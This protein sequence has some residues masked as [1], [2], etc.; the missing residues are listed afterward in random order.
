M[1]SCFC[2]VI[3]CY[4]L[5]SVPCNAMICNVK[6][7]GA[8]GNGQTDDT[9]AIQKAIDSCVGTKDLSNTLLFPSHFNFL[10]Y[11]LSISHA[12]NISIIIES[13][14]LLTAQTNITNWP[15][16]S[17][18]PEYINFFTIGDSKNIIFG[19]NGLIN[20][21]WFIYIYIYCL[22]IKK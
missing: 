17:N 5:V 7:Y 20:G 14:S 3:I 15:I 2:I 11:P 22:C 6:D 19:G 13:N 21:L 12:T 9:I 4:H 1:F 8:V 16:R 18:E 10:S